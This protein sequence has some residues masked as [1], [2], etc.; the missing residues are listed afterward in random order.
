V[1]RI[2]AQAHFCSDVLAGAAVGCLVSA[3]VAN[4]SRYGSQKPDARAT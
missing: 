4:L 1:Q 3:A 2:E